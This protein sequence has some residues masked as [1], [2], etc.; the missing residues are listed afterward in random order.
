MGGILKNG[1]SAL[2]ETSSGSLKFNF[3]ELQPLRNKYAKY[4]LYCAYVPM[5]FNFQK[6][7]QMSTKNSQFFG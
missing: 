4:I 5:V 7:Q 3:P 2:A 6:F 1:I